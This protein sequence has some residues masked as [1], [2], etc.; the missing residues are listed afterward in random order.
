MVIA[1]TA[2]PLISFV[3]ACF[4]RWKRTK[5]FYWVMD[6]NPYE[7]VAA[8]WLRAGSLAERVLQRLSHY[9]LKKAGDRMKSNSTRL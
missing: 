3:G 6:L 9:S 5:V 4:A 2:P 1:L 7:A 8:G